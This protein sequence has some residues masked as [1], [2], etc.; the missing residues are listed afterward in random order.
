MVSC[1]SKSVPWSEHVVAVIVLPVPVTLYQSPGASTSVPSHGLGTPVSTVAV[2]VEPVV[3][4]G[5]ASAMAFSHR[6][7]AG[8]PTVNVTCMTPV[9]TTPSAWPPRRI[10]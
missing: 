7:F 2:V 9:P 8:G 5:M 3:T 1:V 10:R 6:S 4:L